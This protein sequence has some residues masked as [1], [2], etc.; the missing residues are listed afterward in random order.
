MFL[1]T[2]QHTLDG[3]GRVILPAKYR[4]RLLGGIVLAPGKANCIDVYPR[5][6]FER[7]AQKMVDDVEAGREPLSALEY[8]SSQSYE[9]VPDGQGR[10]TIPADLR[11][12]AGLD[13][14]LTVI[15]AIT[16]VAI[17]DRATWQA[18]KESQDDRFPAEVQP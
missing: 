9:E 2:N 15:G 8:L 18:R 12:Y 13:R 3:K 5:T 11:S 1:G 16:R 6:E 7:I 4:D 17:Y 10:V 14:D